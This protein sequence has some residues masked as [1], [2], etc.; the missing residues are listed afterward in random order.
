MS[1]ASFENMSK[2]EKE[3]SKKLAES[4][5]DVK[6]PVVKVVMTA[7][8]Q[9]SLKHSMI[10]DAMTELLKGERPLIGEVELD[11]IASEIEYHIRTEEQM[12]R[13]L[14]ETLE[15]GVENK[16][17]K[18]FLETLLRDELY[19]HALLKKVLEMIVRREAFTESDLWDL[20]WKE[21]TF[22]GTPGG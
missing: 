18:F 9:D 6:N 8:A 21:A 2:L 5:K 20:V 4:A 22:H 12:I 15:R 19:H 7:V 10:Y 1:N 16:A 17:I 3:Y 14:K 13:Y 11:R